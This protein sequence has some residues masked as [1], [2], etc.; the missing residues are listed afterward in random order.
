MSQ[1]DG[2]I[3]G[4][5]KWLESQGYP[6]EMRTAR[7]FHSRNIFATLGHYYVD[8]ETGQ[9]RETDVM[10]RL[11][12][13]SGKSGLGVVLVIECK[14]ARDKPWVLFTGDP[15]RQTSS[16]LFTSLQF[17]TPT[18]AISRMRRGLKPEDAVPL[19][20]G[21]EP[22]GHSLVRAHENGREDVAFGA[23]MSAAK[24]AAGICR[25]L[26]AFGMDEAS[27]VIP[28]V[29]IDSPLVQCTLDDDGEPEISQI[30]CGTVRWRYQVETP[31]S[32]RMGTDVIV[33]TPAA[34][35]K[36]V[37]DLVTTAQSLEMALSRSDSDSDE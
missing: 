29:L 14:S 15:N 1:A 20:S 8:L 3:G 13:G 22:F 32:Y 7:E 35:P 34:L 33:V 25:E 2:L 21:Y 31:G 6:L 17:T 18:E 4:I 9:Q 36:L 30:N 23:M 10:V 19:L 11:N 37:E 12:Q 28:V 16:S 5:A 24:A 26:D 27:V